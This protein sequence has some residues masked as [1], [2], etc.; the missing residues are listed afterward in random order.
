M[1]ASVAAAVRATAAARDG[2][3][4]RLVAAEVTPY[5]IAADVT[6]EESVLAWHDFRRGWALAG[7]SQRTLDGYAFALA[8]LARFAGGTLLGV[9]PALA[10]AFVG[11]L[12]ARP[13]VSDTSVASYHR[14][15]RAWFGWAARPAESGGGGYLA[16]NPFAG[17]P[18]RR[19]VTPVKVVLDDGQL[20]AL[21]AT[22]A[23]KG[24]TEAAEFARLRDAAI[25]R[26]LCEAGSPRVSELAA[27]E[28]GDIDLVTD[29]LVIRNGKGGR[30]R[31]IPLSNATAQA[32]TRYLRA[33]AA[34][35]ARRWGKAARAPQGRRQGFD[36]PPQ[37]RAN[38]TE[39]LWLGKR[40]RF[41]VTGV[42]Q[43][44]RERCA[45]AGVPDVSPHE[46]RHTAYSR[47]EERGGLP[48]DAMAL[49]GWSS[50]TMTKLYG[51]SAAARR[52][53]AKARDL[54]MADF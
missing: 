12:V 9:T 46:L 45:A 38:A 40:G 7:K 34:V 15:L 41:G 1:T 54:H 33:R 43:M 24:R 37:R 35:A 11:S 53:M 50:D 39:S 14:Q 21:L 48:N 28:T 26:V 20:R 25:L 27:L 5:S 29:T 30:A 51:K 31:A 17:L 4:L 52:A 42:Q 47:F 3:R 23:R 49:F 10:R 8:Q 36:G 32:L 6:D 13:G 2:A 18:A 19:S 44:L 16:A 22:T